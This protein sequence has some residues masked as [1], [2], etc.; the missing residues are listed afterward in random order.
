MLWKQVFPSMHFIVIQCHLDEI[1]ECCIL[2]AGGYPANVADVSPSD[3]RLG[4]GA[5]TSVPSS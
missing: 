5:T 4:F 1:G 3:V 2:Y